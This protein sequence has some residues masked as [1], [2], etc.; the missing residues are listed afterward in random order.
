MKEL[1]A[2]IGL[3][4]GLIVSGLFG[5]ILTLK[6]TAGQTLGTTLISILTGV[7]SANYLTPIFIDLLNIQT[8][9]LKFGIAF[10]LGYLGLNGIEYAI[11]RLLNSSAKKGD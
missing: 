10:L 11:N 8:N 2:E 1:L 5:S 6:R 3:N 4:I 7:G 9:N